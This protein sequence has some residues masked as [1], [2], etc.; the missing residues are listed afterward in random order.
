MIQRI[1]SFY[2]LLT[3]LLSS[4]FLSDSYLRFFNKAGTQIYMNFRGLWES[5]SGGNP[6]MKKNLLP[7][8]LIMVGI[9]IV[10]LITLLLYKNRKT[11]IKMTFVVILLSLVLIILVLF[12]AVWITR[13]YDV[14][15]APGFSMFVPLLQLTLAILALKGIKKDEKLVRTYERL[16]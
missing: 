16:R 6:E 2:L 11:Q 8:S 1:Q 5:H 9:A 4:L 3:S 15:L 13:N 7:V 10:S 14:V 12:Y